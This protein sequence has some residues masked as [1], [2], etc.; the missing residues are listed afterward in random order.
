MATRGVPVGQL[1]TWQQQR[2]R[3]QEQEQEPAG[4]AGAG[5]EGKEEV[6]MCVYVCMYHAD[7]DMALGQDIRPRANTHTTQHNPIRRRLLP[8][9]STS[10]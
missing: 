2:Q 3:Q 9:G 1:P 8:T 10:C 7:L 4:A 6:C 5:P